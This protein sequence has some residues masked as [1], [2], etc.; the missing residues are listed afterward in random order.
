MKDGVQHDL[1]VYFLAVCTNAICN[2]ETLIKHNCLKR[3]I[4]GMSREGGL[5]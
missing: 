5:Y 2:L 3:N 4:L 1:N